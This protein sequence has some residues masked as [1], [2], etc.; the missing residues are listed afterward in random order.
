MSGKPKGTGFSSNPCSV[1]GCKSK[2]RN[3]G[4]CNAHYHRFKRYG[5]PTIMKRAVSNPGITPAFKKAWVV[6][7][8]L[9]KGCVDCGYNKH[10][11]ALDFD[12]L[13]GT[14]KLRDIKCGQHLGWEALQAEVAKCEV[15]CANCHRIR[16][17]ERAKGG[18]EGVLNLGRQADA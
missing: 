11:A 5:D 4:M 13:P 17:S 15:V 16:T 7:Y 6:A 10:P 18:D 1:T 12:H 2:G 9:E 8:K 3:H 14:E